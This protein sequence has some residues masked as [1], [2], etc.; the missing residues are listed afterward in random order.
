MENESDEQLHYSHDDENEDK[1]KSSTFRKRRLSLPKHHLQPSS[2][3][4]E[5][6]DNLDTK[7]ETEEKNQSA[8]S[9]SEVTSPSADEKAHTFRKRRLSLTT[10]SHNAARGESS[11]DAHDEAGSNKRQRR[12]SEVSSTS[13]KSTPERRRT[14]TVHADELL[15]AGRAPPS[16]AIHRDNVLYTNKPLVRPG[17]SSS[18]LFQPSDDL[19]G[20]EEKQQEDNKGSDLQRIPR[21]SY[22]QTVAAEEEHKLPFPLEIVGTYSCHGV[23]PIYGDDEEDEDEEEAWPPPQSGKPAAFAGTHQRYDSSSSDTEDAEANESAARKRPEERPTMVAKINQDRGGVAY[24]YG[25]NRRIALFAVYDGHGQGGE[26]VSQFALHEVQRRLEKHPD[27]GTNDGKALTDVFLAVDEALKDEPLIEPWYSGT[28]ACVALLTKNILTLA[29]A[30]DSRAVMARKTAEGSSWDAVDL[31]IDQN[32]DLPEEMERIT[33]QGGY[34]SPAPAPGLSARVWLDPHYTQ[35][36]L[37]MARSIGDHAVSE[38]GVIAEP[39]ISTYEINAQDDFM[40]LASDGVWE[41]ITS[42]DAVRIVGENLDR[43]ATKACQALIEAA[44]AK[45]HEEEGEYRDD[46][47]AIVVKIKSLWEKDGI[48]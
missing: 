23:E 16:P 28:T 21:W 13:I 39:V 18:L 12:Y 17:S 30:G 2:P 37:A 8:E 38:V 1:K 45:W 40:I 29:N 27:F 3:T 47:T 36:G 42:A 44:A 34:V 11:D 33:A 14:K 15:S 24:P 43:G 35:I 26:F 5:Q 7:D 6:S 19:D 22:R 9:Q 31:T 46:I 25:N 20:D 32:P 48:V 41:F 10:S 4:K